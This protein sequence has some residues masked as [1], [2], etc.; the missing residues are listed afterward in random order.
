MDDQRRYRKDYQ[1]IGQVDI[2]SSP[3][4]KLLIESSLFEDYDITH[5]GHGP[6]DLRGGNLKLSGFHADINPFSDNMK[7]HDDKNVKEF[8]KSSI[9]RGMPNKGKTICYFNSIIQALGSISTFR[10]Y[11]SRCANTHSQLHRLNEKPPLAK[12]LLDLI[13]CINGASASNAKRLDN[14]ST[15]VLMEIFP[16]SYNIWQ[17]QDAQEFLLI[18][19]EHLEDNFTEF[20]NP[21]KGW[22]TVSLKCQACRAVKPLQNQLFFTLPLA[23]VMSCSNLSQLLNNFS[24]NATVEGVECYSCTKN[25]ILKA[26]REDQVLYQN[27]I[28]YETRFKKNPKLSH[29]NEQVDVIE[30]KIRT[31][32][33][34]NFHDESFEERLKNFLESFSP[35]EADFKVSKQC[36]NRRELISRPP[37]V[38]ALHIHRRTAISTKVHKIISLPLNL[39]VSSSLASFNPSHTGTSKAPNNEGKSRPI[40]YSLKSVVEHVGSA[41]G[42]HYQTYRIS[43][44]GQWYFISDERCV[45]LSIMELTM[46]FLLICK[47]ISRIISVDFSVVAKA[48]A[49][50]LFYEMCNQ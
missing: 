16:R 47:C 45:S 18:L 5:G 9:V 1:S 28:D 42:G 50:M 17:Q 27:A 25:A 20:E 26:W 3:L 31:T 29:L 37:L 24:S 43:D 36:F 7:Q 8:A 40:M 19:F 30:T 33:A 14:L 22:S 4:S 13:S 48:Q 11:L 44:E 38:F 46:I 32:T 6:S 35:S 39:D 23:A 21:F 34:I 41:Q 49:Y 15:M 10:E 12:T 2:V